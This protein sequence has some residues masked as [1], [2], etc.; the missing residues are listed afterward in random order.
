[1]TSGGMGKNELSANDTAASVGKAFGPFESSMTL[2]YMSLSMALAY[3]GR[4]RL[5]IQ[6][7]HQRLQFSAILCRRW[8]RICACSPR[9]A[10]M[11]EFGRLAIAAFGLLGAAAIPG[12]DAVAAGCEQWTMPLHL[13]IVQSN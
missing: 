4:V 6:L 1:M 9:G 3:R 7:A 13:Q 2:S 10:P 11:A 12:S 5:S 8:Q